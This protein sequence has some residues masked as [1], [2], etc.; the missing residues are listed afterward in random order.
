MGLDTP[1]FAITRLPGF[2]NPIFEGM[3]VSLKC[4]VDSNPSSLPI[5]QCG[6]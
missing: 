3:A 1:S 6:E 4:D 5:W 2:G